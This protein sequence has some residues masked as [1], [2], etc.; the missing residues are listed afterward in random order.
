MEE[1]RKGQSGYRE[2]ETLIHW[3]IVE[4]ERK[5]HS[6]QLGVE[7]LTDR[8]DFAHIEEASYSEQHNCYVYRKNRWDR[9]VP[10]FVIGE[11][12]KYRGLPDFMVN[13]TMASE[14]EAKLSKDGRTLRVTID[15]E[16]RKMRSNIIIDNFG[17]YFDLYDGKIKQIDPTLHFFKSADVR[18]ELIGD[19]REPTRFIEMLKARFGSK[20]WEIVR[21]HLAGT[22][23]HTDNLGSRPKA[24]TLVGET[25][26][27][28]STVIEKFA[29]L[30][31]GGAVSTATITQLTRDNFGKALIA[32]KIL[33]HSQEE[34][35]KSMQYGHEVLKD[36]ITATT[37]RVR[38]MYSSDME[39]AYRYPRWILA[40]NK[41]PTIGKDDE[42][43]SIFNRFLYIKSLPVGDQDMNWREFF[44]TVREK[45]EILMYFLRRAHEICR[46][47]KLMRTQSLEETRLVY[48]ELTTGTLT[49][50]LGLT[51][52]SNDVSNFQRTDSNITGIGYLE[53]LKKFREYTGSSVS[54][55]KFNSM[56]EELD[57]EKSRE[58]C[59]MKDD[60]THTYEINS[61]GPQITLILG[62]ER[63]DNKKPPVDIRVDGKTATLD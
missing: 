52:E 27:W 17:N 56:L 49:I 23:L 61:N 11:L 47:P 18:Y 60:G 5:G 33:N 14:T 24:L 19:A 10:N 30:F 38:V 31:D 6:V 16:Y 7:L 37:D 13:K 32:N 45:Q 29:D 55:S 51:E 57:I 26:T 46:E 48:T 21:D 15:D 41:L 43:A 34:T 40:T 25:G 63:T 59:M 58:R 28:K 2:L 54:K 35:V 20:N 1:Y 9:N 42:D 3:C 8:Y 39:P 12:T 44:E 36:V 50:F 22:F 4:H 62:F 53:T